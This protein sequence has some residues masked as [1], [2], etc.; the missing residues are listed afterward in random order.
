MTY[1]A[2]HKLFIESW[3]GNFDQNAARFS[4]ATI[5][6]ACVADHFSRKMMEV[7]SYRCNPV[8]QAGNRTLSFV[9]PCQYWW[10]ESNSLGLLCKE[11]LC[12]DKA[13]RHSEAIHNSSHGLCRHDRLHS[14]W[15][16]C[17]SNIRRQCWCGRDP[18]F[19]WHLLA[20]KITTNQCAVLD[21]ANNQNNQAV[22][23][24][25]DAAFGGL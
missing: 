10:F 19:Y 22:R 21:N 9:Q 24:R 17:L 1:A 3:F 15:D 11:G 16:Y 2:I 20:P 7:R 8:D 14:A 5:R 23:A 6:N 4:V 18:V 12:S 25:L 13:A